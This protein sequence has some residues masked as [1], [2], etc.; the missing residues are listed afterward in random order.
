[1]TFSASTPGITYTVLTSTDLANWTAEGVT[2]LNLDAE[3]RRTATIDTTAP[4]RFMRLVVE[5]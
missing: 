2:L 4:R 5:E 1:M 3:G